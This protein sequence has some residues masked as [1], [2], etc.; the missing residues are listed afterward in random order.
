MDDRL[1]Q[2]E[3]TLGFDPPAPLDQ[4]R[5][6]FERHWNDVA[7]TR[8]E[9]WLAHVPDTERGPLLESMIALE[10]KLRRSR[11]ETPT[12]SEY[13]R[14]FPGQDDR[15]IRAFG[16]GARG[17]GDPPSGDLATEK[18]TIS[19]GKPADDD[20]ATEIQ[21]GIVIGQ[22]YVIVRF[23][24]R[25]STAVV[26]Q[27]YDPV[28][29][30]PVALKMPRSDGFRSD[31]ELAN[32]I[33]EARNAVRLD[34]SGIVK[35]YDVQPEP[36]SIFIVQQYIDGSNLSAL[37]KSGRQASDRAVDLIIGVA[38]ALDFAHRHG[39]VHRDVK[40]ANIL[41]D[42][43][44]RPYL[45]DF[46][47]ALHESVQHHHW[48]ELAGTCQYMSPEQV[49]REVHRLDGRS[50]LW[51]LGVI[52][53][54][55]LAGARPFT[56]T[57][58]EQL[59]EQI[60]RHDPRP[61]RELDP[62]APE[63]L[64]RICLKCLSKRAAERYAS[65]A[66]LID[67][68]RHW[69]GAGRDGPPRRDAQAARVVPR[70]LRSF[71]TGDAEF[72]LELLPGPRDREGLPEG[73]RF[74]KKQL[75][76]SDPDERL[77]VCLM[78]GPSGSGKS[79]LVKA[80]LIPRLAGH[81]LPVYI[82]ATPSETESRLLRALRRHI[83]DL[84]A[85]AT[86]AD[87]FARLRS[88]RG[89]AGKKVLVVIDQFEQWLHADDGRG[90]GELVRA[91]RQSD[92]GGVQCLLLVRDDFWMSTTRFMQALEVLQVE[93]LN[94][95]AVDLFDAGHAAKVL[96]AFG[97]AFGKLPDGGLS[98]AQEQFLDL[99]AA[100]LARDGKVVSVRLALFAEMMKGRPW[101]AAGLEEI[102]G[103]EGVDLSFLE[104]TFSA[105]TAPPA[106]RLHQEAARAVLQALLPEHGPDIRGRMQPRERLLD[107][108]GYA[109]RPEDFRDLL[110]ILDGELRLITPTEPGGPASNADGLPSAPE[111][112]YYQLTHD[113]LV[114]SLRAW[115]SNTR[116]GRAEI[117][118]ED[119]TALWTDRRERKQLPSWW[120]WAE[121]RS[122]TRRAAWTGPQRRMMRAAARHHLG[123]AA[124]LAGGIVAM[125]AAG[126]GWRQLLA[127]EAR[128]ELAV[129]Q[130]D[131]L[132]HVGWPHMS[133]HLDE[134]DDHP[135]L[136]RRQVEED[137]ERPGAPPDQRV[138]GYLALA[139]LDGAGLDHL[140]RRLLE[141]DALEAQAIRDELRRWKD[142]VVPGLWR[143]ASDPATS[144]KA[145]LAAAMALAE[146]DP[147][148][149]RWTSIAGPVA[150]ELIALN[151]LLVTPL[152][153]PLRP[154]RGH[155]R[156]PL[157]EGF[158]DP[159]LGENP[160]LLAA[161][162]LANFAADG[163]ARY[164]PADDLVG[165]VLEATPAQTAILL[166]LARRR[167]EELA[168]PLARVLEKP[169]PL[170]DKP[171][172]ERLVRRQANAAEA[173]LAL[174][175]DDAFW[176]RLRKS[177]DPRLRT[178]LIDHIPATSGWEA[179]LGRFDREKD[180]SIRQAILIGLR[181]LET[182]LSE[183]DRRL[184]ADRL[185]DLYRTDPDGGVHGA[186]EW[187]LACWGFGARVADAKHGLVGP[188]R[189]DRDWFVTPQHHTMIV[190]RRPGTFKV[191]SPIGED[192]RDEK[193]EVQH[194]VTIDYTFAISAHEVTR[195]QYNKFRGGD[196]QIDPKVTQNDDCPA[197]FIPW[198]KA[199]R[200]CRW[201]GDEEKIPRDQQ[202]YPAV[203][204]I[205]P[206][207]T[208][209]L[210][211]DH[212]RRLSYRLPTEE[213]WEYVTRAG[214]ATSRFFGNSPA[215]LDKYAWSARNSA[216]RTWPVGRLRPNP[217]GLFD[218]YG[219]VSEWCDPGTSLHDP[220]RAGFR[221][222]NYTSTERFHRSAMPERADL[223]LMPGYSYLG[224]RI[225]KVL[226]VP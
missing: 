17:P 135:E 28:L 163:D 32:F 162:V 179:L 42:S 133:R 160:R 77:A 108:S 52:L 33:R 11:G 88:D 196:L 176:P 37:M 116:R 91:L 212:C 218:V 63:E 66:E 197:N 139:R 49:R 199:A 14:R 35:T 224:F 57:N 80:G 191:G 104:Q 168:G 87:A 41:V 167:R 110:E 158:A 67:D 76:R 221:G 72:F 13:L 29:E 136:W 181:G 111:A 36:K 69:R 169:A 3:T 171:E 7:P 124:L 134:M 9:P 140:S 97:R 193:A 189:A 109:G 144:A 120:E 209:E 5:D 25:G 202:C 175:G 90:D 74:W 185:V 149:P 178:Q 64:S 172:S 79:S 180:G 157:A 34:F 45:S 39:I 214:S 48:G 62:S 174:G 165:L 151:P 130:I 121:I 145:R 54:E 192:G 220:A 132:W 141:A 84:P 73:L 187:V 127:Q 208:V 56:A 213:E 70:G 27:A 170:D 113:F 4:F 68:L 205:E 23:L 61:P 147:L 55:M 201:V 161:S 53:Y 50:D 96:R 153:D 222:G 219:N 186:A 83:P 203:E 31:A 106:H 12:V 207:M 6:E 89:A 138:R 146:Y 200:Y 51:S 100:G 19:L 126:L 16:L 137:A 65:A 143:E 223:A 98:A 177:D 60:E 30:R 150:R 194:E 156:S 154:V 131:Y 94:S 59:F 198:Y 129:H 188:Y 8:I 182:G 43:R 20:L 226:S 40:P 152:V 71:D 190:I 166:P 105:P 93:G 85:A 103:P 58:S 225:V 1:S 107:V 22:R 101:T 82:E 44:G 38:E 10:L 15:V 128:R 125:V 142:R 204:E 159:K 215:C 78:Y 118:L 210:P 102:G 75:E 99:S 86:L 211:E 122:R 95:A 164:L 119:R 24:G 117:L 26:Y 155:L 217:L 46:G 195:A 115:L 173:L 123:R 183:S 47:L 21:A 184:V 206:F 2:P 114:P 148:D 81:V 112:R 216:E 18:Q 92:G